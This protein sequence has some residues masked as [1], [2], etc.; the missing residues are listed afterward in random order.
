[1]EGCSNCPDQSVNCGGADD[2]TILVQPKPGR[3][4]PCSYWRIEV[5]ITFL[6]GVVVG[7]VGILVWNYMKPNKVAKFTAKYKD[8][9]EE[10]LAK[11][12]R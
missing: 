11:L 10:E 2:S 1:M 6:M 5:M 7:A 12:R 9:I 4:Y 8:Q 3:Q